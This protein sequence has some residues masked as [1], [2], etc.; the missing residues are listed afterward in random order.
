MVKL[1]GCRT[2]NMYGRFSRR[3]HVFAKN[4]KKPRLGGGFLKQSQGLLVDG[5]GTDDFD[6]HAAVLGAA[7]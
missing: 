3:C 1:T 7:A 6:F 2:E 5:T 4:E